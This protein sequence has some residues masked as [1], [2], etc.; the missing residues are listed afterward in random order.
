[1][2]LVHKVRIAHAHQGKTASARQLI[3]EVHI[4]LAPS[5]NVSGVAAGSYNVRLETGQNAIAKSAPKAA[6][7]IFE[8]AEYNREVDGPALRGESM[9]VGQGCGLEGN[10]HIKDKDKVRSLT[11]SEAGSQALST[12]KLPLAQDDRDRGRVL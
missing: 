3:K 10:V 7:A 4:L 1:M 8:L 2:I 11:G 5:G 9:G 6:V 12:R